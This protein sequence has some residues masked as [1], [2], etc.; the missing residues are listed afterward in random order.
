MSFHVI[1]PVETAQWYLTHAFSNARKKSSQLPKK[2]NSTLET[3]KRIVE[4]KINQVE[5]TLLKHLTGLLESFPKTDQLTE[6]YQ[7]LMRV[8]LDFVE[9]KQ[10]FGAL[11]WAKK[12]VQELSRTHSRRARYARQL[13]DVSAVEREY[14]GRISSVFKQ[15][16]Q[17]LEELSRARHVIIEYPVIKKCY[18]VAIAGFPN[19]GKS[20]LLYALT[21]SNPGIKNYPFTTTTIKVGYRQIHHT[22]VQFLDTPGTLLRPEK[23]NIVEK[24]AYLALKYCADL[25]IFVIDPT[26]ELAHQEKLFASLK[27]Y[28]KPMFV[29]LSKT[30]IVEQ[31]TTQKLQGTFSAMTS[32][33]EVAKV[34]EEQ[35]TLMLS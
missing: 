15:I 30:D 22:K 2:G 34:V 3:T 5:R 7:Q 18:T 19:V 31:I 25:I 26:M 4:W 28:H 11:V 14:Y 27:E 29:Y 10:S 8:T 23:M 9:F 16:K 1:P 35:M 12:K 13:S 33:D 24:Q 6:F 21:G 32:K 20:T 17:N